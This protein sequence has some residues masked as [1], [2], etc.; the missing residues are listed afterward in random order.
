MTNLQPPGSPAPG[1][2]LESDDEI[3]RVQELLRKQKSGTPGAP[4]RKARSFRPTARPPIAVLVVCDDGRSIGEEI[5]V[6]S[7]QFIIGRSEGDYVL[8][9]DE[10]MS[11][12]HIAISRQLVS[13]KWRWAVTDL[14]SKNGVFFRVTKAV[15]APG[16][17]FLIGGG[18]YR[19]KKNPEAMP[20]TVIGAEISKPVSTKAQRAAELA[21]VAMLS[22]VVLGDTGSQIALTRGAYK[23]GAAK[24]CD[25]ARL[26]DQFA[27]DHHATLARDA[28]GVWTIE[29]HASKNGVWVRLPQISI[30]ER[31]Q[32]HFQ[33]GEQRFR[34]YFGAKR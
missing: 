19:F 32:C 11:S 27:D 13:G 9:L 24:H 29:N 8:P 1:T 5:R 22:E 34:L 21:G 12:R 25:I 30:G 4:T 33:A 16:M 20:D 7:E 6:R 10:L 17:E 26:D 14:Q 28:A 31:G 2:I 23:I 3:R 15:L 18:R